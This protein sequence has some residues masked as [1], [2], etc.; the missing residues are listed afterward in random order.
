MT[1]WR[2]L[3]SGE[4]KEL[5]SRIY[6]FTVAS[7][8][9]KN[10]IKYSNWREQW[11]ELNEASRKELVEQ[12][13]ALSSRP[14][15]SLILDATDWD[16]PSF[17]STIKSVIE[18]LYPD[19]IL[20]ITNGNMLDPDIAEKIKKL[21]DNRIK[22]SLTSPP[23]PNNWVLELNPGTQLHEAALFAS[24]VSINKNPEVS[25]LYS[26]HDHM[27]PHGNFCDPYMKPDWNPDLF[28]AM[29]Y[30]TPFIVFKRELWSNHKKKEPDQDL[31][32]VEIAKTLYHHEIF[33]IPHVL[34]TL[35]VNDDGTHLQPTCKRV[36]YDLPDPAPTVSILIPTHD[37]GYVLERCLKSIFEK[38]DYLS[39]E[40]IL[41][42]HETTELKALNVISEFKGFEHFKVINYSG[43]FNFSAIMNHAAKVAE[44]QILISLNNDTEVI[45]SEWLKELVSQVSRP[46]VG[47]V[48]ALLLFGDGTIQHAG[49]HP[50][51]D[52][53]MGHGHKHLPGE[54]PGYFN[55]LKA[56]HEVAA[57]TGACLA[58][59]KSTWFDLGGLDEEN[60]AV[61][62][63]D[64]DLCFKAKRKGLRVIF[65]PFAR[66]V[67]HESVSRGVDDDLTV[68][69]RLRK[70][71]ETMQDRWGEVIKSDPAYSPNLSFDGGSFKLAEKPKTLN[72]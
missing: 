40:I 28:A 21:N 19:W 31:P 29:N 24:A 42:D 37:Q 15:F 43:S 25:L 54:T 59:E 48:G 50:G 8:D 46:E 3:K 44:G 55:R 2:L 53:L 13:E 47:V 22:N 70:E 51:E 64:I 61:A 38:T 65:T 63:N 72:F 32:L 69:T 34:A 17:F 67:H 35:Q 45:D 14:S 52:G 39:F 36:L 4:H 16:N 49:V 62:Y 30:L 6:K 60:L 7:S 9:K 18:Q 23:E 27:D 71:L 26:D 56:V 33:H 68:N 57:V 58:I 10:P 5:L 41:V 12:I 1:A 66:L 20:C 11:V